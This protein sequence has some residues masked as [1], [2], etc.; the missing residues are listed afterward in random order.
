M[1]WANEERMSLADRGPVDL[2]MALALIHH[3]AISNNVP[4]PRIADFLASLS[5]HLLI[6][7]VPKQDS[8]VQRL[9]VTRE[10]IFDGYTQAGFEA[11]FARRYETVEVHPIRESART[12]YLLRRRA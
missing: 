4:L 3:L 6:E 9:L 5:P 12:L 8:Q 7:F 2:L 10:D 1:G 11:A